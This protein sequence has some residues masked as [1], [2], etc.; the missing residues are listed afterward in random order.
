MHLLIDLGNSRLKWCLIK[1]DVVIRRGSGTTVYFESDLRSLDWTQISSIG[2]CSVA[3]YKITE[4]ISI[5]C[6]SQSKS[7]CEIQQ[8]NLEKLPRCFSLGSTIMSQ[9]GQDR[10]MAMLGAYTNGS[11]YGVVDAGTACTIDYVVDGE[12]KGGYI[13]PGV[14][15]ARSSL[16]RQT[17]R[18]ALV[19]NFACFDN[20][21]PACSTQLSV[22]HGVRMSLIAAV[23]CAIQSSPWPLD[24]VAVTGGDGE[25]LCKHLH[26][27]FEFRGDLVFEGMHRFFHGM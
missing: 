26:G 8:I 12:H 5:H 2:L 16:D 18:I 11:S 3:D 14:Q 21:E 6:D 22:E 24:K 10:V 23:Q 25:W 1:S 9:I 19:D 17:A 7:R 4:A 15:L 13:V 27:P 20:L